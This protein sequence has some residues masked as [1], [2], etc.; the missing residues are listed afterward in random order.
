MKLLC[1]R[2]N[3][4]VKITIKLLYSTFI[5]MKLN[6]SSKLFHT[7][8]L[9]YST[10]N[11]YFI[12]ETDTHCYQINIA[13]KTY[14]NV[15]DFWTSLCF[16]GESKVILSTPGVFVGLVTGVFVFWFLLLSFHCNMNCTSFEYSP[17]FSNI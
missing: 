10:I 8:S 15:R 2:N 3:F 9:W 17:H 12:N 13:L 11:T 14:L 5:V 6:C 7:Y 1:S 16:S 4:N